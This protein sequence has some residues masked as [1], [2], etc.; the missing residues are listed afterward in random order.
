MIGLKNV[1]KGLSVMNEWNYLPLNGVEITAR[2]EIA[3]SKPK[4]K[5]FR[6]VKSKPNQY[7]AITT[8]WINNG[9]H[10]SKLQSYL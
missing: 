3:N 7:K 9:L 6:K 5:A 8:S 4:S 2:Y 10:K 1:Y